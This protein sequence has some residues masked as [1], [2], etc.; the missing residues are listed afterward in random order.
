MLDLET[1]GYF[2]YM[3]E[4]EKSQNNGQEV[5]V[6]ENENDF[7]REKEPPITAFQWNI[8]LYPKICPGFVFSIGQNGKLFPF[9]IS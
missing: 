1:I 9:W 2:L 4:M 3:E 7:S 6:V 8:V 5:F